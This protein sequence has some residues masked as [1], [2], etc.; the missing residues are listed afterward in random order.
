[1]MKKFYDISLT[2]SEKLPVWPGDKAVEI[3]QTS[4]M[5]KG[6]DCNVSLFSMS[7]HAG[8][9]IDAPLH[10]INAGKST[11]DMDLD[12]FIGKAKVFELDVQA[13]IELEHVSGLDICAGDIVLLKI[14]KNE[15]L[16][17]LEEFRHDFVGLS[18]KAAQYLAGKTIKS[19][20]IDYYSIERS[21]S[22]GFSVHKILLGNG[23]GIIE[24]VKLEEI[25][26][27]EYE[28]LCL[29]LKLKN[30]NGSPVRAVLVKDA[31]G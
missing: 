22:C 21:D 1:M 3:L 13:D 19:V 31:G 20:G 6:D 15:E 18:T 7:M 9:H 23:I 24:G 27:G 10:F 12:R 8:T 28:L 2:L 14:L 5:G 30:G 25:E 29:P 4:F 17:K 11:E 16:L 26:P